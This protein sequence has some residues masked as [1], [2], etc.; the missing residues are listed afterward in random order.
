MVLNTDPLAPPTPADERY[1]AW[2]P[3]GDQ[4]AFWSGTGNSGF[5]EADIWVMKA[6]DGSGKYDL[7]DNP[8]H[9]EWGDIEPDWGPAPHNQ[10]KSSQ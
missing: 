4:I 5:T 6:T 2:S 9:P 10:K 3:E 1:P 8:E 7:T